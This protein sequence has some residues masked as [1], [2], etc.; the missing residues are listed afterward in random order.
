MTERSMLFPTL[1]YSSDQ[2]N[3]YCSFHFVQC[4]QIQKSY[5]QQT[6]DNKNA[7]LGWQFKLF[8][9]SIYFQVFMFVSPKT[10]DKYVLKP[11]YWTLKCYVSEKLYITIWNLSI[12][13]F[14]EAQLPI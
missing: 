12:L 1:N 10:I 11:K 6:N 3:T 7:D 14:I 4:R 8:I 13:L 5:T 9:S 2:W